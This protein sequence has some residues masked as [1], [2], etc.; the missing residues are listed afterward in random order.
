ML[1]AMREGSGGRRFQSVSEQLR[2]SKAVA[3]AAVRSWGPAVRHASERLRADLDVVLAA[4][5]SQCSA[6]EWVRGSLRLFS[7]RG[8]DVVAAAVQSRAAALRFYQEMIQ[9]RHQHGMRRAQEV[10][11]H[12]EATLAQLRPQEPSAASCTEWQR[13]SAGDPWQLDVNGC[14]V[15]SPWS[16]QRANTN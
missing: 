4:V 10:R 11:S 16:S 2:D 12:A 15:H 13:Q 7:D 6:L 5:S 3:L 1:A 8:E 9:F 14:N